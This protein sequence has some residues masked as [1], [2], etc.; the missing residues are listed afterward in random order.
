VRLGKL[1][2]DAIDE[3]G[4][5]QREVAKRLGIPQP[6][7]SLIVNYKFEGFSIER[8]MNLLIRMN[9]TVT[10]EVGKQKLYQNSK[11][12]LNAAGESSFL[13]DAAIGVACRT[14]PQK[15]SP[16]RFA[17]RMYASALKLQDVHAYFALP[18]LS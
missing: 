3:C 6:N 1:L 16:V 14:T 15:K 2:I 4:L 18:R 10:I 13:R 7:I 17:A 12:D 5:S 9:R 11:I 8:F